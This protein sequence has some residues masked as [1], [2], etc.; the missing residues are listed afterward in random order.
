M[1]HSKSFALASLFLAA[2]LEAP[3]ATAFSASSDRR[4]FLQTAVGGAAEV[5]GNILANCVWR[6]HIGHR[7]GKGAGNRIAVAVVGFVRD[8]RYAHWEQ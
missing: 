8:R 3:F 4:S 2:V 6:L 5:Y 1:F 7:N